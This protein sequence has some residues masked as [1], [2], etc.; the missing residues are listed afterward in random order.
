[1][2]TRISFTNNSI[3]AIRETRP[4][5]PKH[6]LK[7]PR[8]EKYKAEQNTRD[9]DLPRRLTVL[10]W[11]ARSAKDFVQRWVDWRA[12]GNGTRGRWW[13]LCV[14]ESTIDSLYGSSSSSFT[15]LAHPHTYS[16]TSVRTFVATSRS[17]AHFCG[18]HVRLKHFAFVTSR[19]PAFAQLFAW[20]QNSWPFSRRRQTV[21]WP[22][23]SEL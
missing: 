11:R 15:G 2:E 22:T 8:T 23:S 20:R 7:T 1:M 5:R 14:Q 3:L 12:G 10:E 16:R 4:T 18:H 17:V 6:H 21:I 13:Q 19:S 9:Q